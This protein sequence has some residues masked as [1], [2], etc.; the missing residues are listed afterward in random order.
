MSSSNSNSSSRQDR[1]ASRQPPSSVRDSA[2]SRTSFS[3]TSDD[4]P[5][6]DSGISTDHNR[7]ARSSVGSI[8]ESVSSS[9][10]S[11]RHMP[12][13]STLLR[14]S[15][16]VAASLR[17]SASAVTESLVD[18]H[19]S[20]MR[21]GGR[22]LP[23][24]VSNMS[25]SVG[26]LA[27]SE[28]E[29]V[30]IED[31]LY[32]LMGVEGTYI[33]YRDGPFPLTE[34][35]RDNYQY[36]D[37]AS[38]ADGKVFAISQA[39]DASLADLLLRIVPL[40]AYANI[41][42]T[43]CDTYSR[44]DAG[45]VAHALCGAL[46]GLLK[47]Y[48]ILVAQ[49]EHQFRTN[50]AFTLQ[51]VWFYLQPTLHIL[52]HCARFA[53]A[54][55]ELVDAEAN[56]PRLPSMVDVADASAGQEAD[57]SAS[58]A[59]AGKKR[60]WL[61]RGGGLLG[62]LSDRMLAYSGDAA[63]RALYSY[64]LEAATR[65]YLTLLHKWILRG[66]IFDPYDEFMVKESATIRKENLKSDYSDAYWERRYT[67]RTS[68][69]PPFLE[70][71]K[72]KVLIAGKYLNVV[73]ECGIKVT[74]PES[75]DS[76]ATP[77]AA[78]PAAGRPELIKAVDGNGRFVQDIERAYRFAN[79]SL[80]DLL[81][82]NQNLVARL[83]SIKRYFFL[84][85]SDFFTYFLDQASDELRKPA[86]QISVSKL[87]STLELSLRN[88]ASVTASDPYKDDLKV[89]LSDM[90]LKDH[91]SRILGVVGMNPDG[92]LSSS[93]ADLAELK[94][95][96]KNELMTGFDALLFHYEVPFP[97]SLV[98]TTRALTKYQ[99]LFRNMFAVKQLE[100]SLCTVWQ[101]S[102]RVDLWRRLRRAN[103]RSNPQL[104]RL[105]WRLQQLRIRM[106]TFV[107]QLGYYITS[108][109]LEPNWHA[110]EA[111]LAKMRKASTVD[112]VLQIHG[113]FLDTCLIDCMLTTDKLLSCLN[114]LM[115]L[116]T[117]FKR[118]SDECLVLISAELADIKYADPTL[119][120]TVT[121][122]AIR[123]AAFMSASPSGGGGDGEQQRQYSQA[124]RLMRA[125]RSVQKFNDSWG[126]YMRNFIDMLTMCSSNV[127]S[128]LLYLIIR[129]DYNGFY[130]GDKPSG[131]LNLMAGL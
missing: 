75:T 104:M 63:T 21:A 76:D 20:P 72:D 105:E 109:V 19:K 95:T 60:N 8:G 34:L 36:I 11:L 24:K 121:P 70:S 92:S 44:F 116:C 45:L 64:L 96:G 73:A 59:A 3:S 62:L 23:R 101:E 39:I 94:E 55:C 65:P 18:A 131:P 41:V 77:P 69:I 30:L 58:S 80:L 100:R 128:Q 111:K 43:F 81:V 87:Q 120:L 26:A 117:R 6:R 99:L 68:A 31:L 89:T 84:D 66:Q 114:Q 57:G 110:L 7:L 90:R 54:V 126:A 12:S 17:S 40:A 16:A 123:H 48:F 61:P 97:L 33:S 71:L 127:S 106:I 107:Q 98:I 86:K 82:N 22:P 130:A 113:D 103:D 14:S 93:T 112:E 91:L 29:S 1:R 102:T 27:E 52:H 32:V 5:I 25:A 38:V 88:P 115:Y 79:K 37:M 53:L 9:S 83:R 129:L 85:Q 125:D 28:Q 50:A 13:M 49:L 78:L 124:E 122:T 74:V 15:S 47:E 51:K 35:S 10:T 108:D 46:R 2:I 56:M 42:H 118:F 67:F 119:N 4:A